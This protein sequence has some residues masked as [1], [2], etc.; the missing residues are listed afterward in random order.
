MIHINIIKVIE[1][2]SRQYLKPKTSLSD[3]STAIK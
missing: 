1:V 3:I 2:G